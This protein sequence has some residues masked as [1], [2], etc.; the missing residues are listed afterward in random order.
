MA[1]QKTWTLR[2]E[3][4]NLKTEEQQ[5][6]NIS[7]QLF[8]LTKKESSLDS[9]LL[10][11]NLENKSMENNLLRFVNE[12]AKENHIKIIDFNSPHIYETNSSSFTTYDLVLRGDFLSIVKSINSIESQSSFGE[13]VHVNFVKQ[14]N[15]RTSKNFLEA[16]IF[17]QKI[18]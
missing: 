10:A 9:I 1:I 5:F 7:Q 4:L 15:Y 17:I 2:K 18:E 13:I 11:L 3:Y 8:A 6:E 12:V 16:T 14:K